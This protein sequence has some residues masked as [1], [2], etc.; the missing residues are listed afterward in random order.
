MTLYTDYRSILI[1]VAP[2]SSNT[3]TGYTKFSFEE[4]SLSIPHSGWTNTKCAEAFEALPNLHNV[5]CSV[6]YSTDLYGGFT[7]LV[8]LAEFP[9]LPYQNNVYAHDGNP[10]LSSFQCDTSEVVSTDSVLCTIT[11]VAVNALP[12]LSPTTRLLTDHLTE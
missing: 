3:F 8:E 2:V 11:D 4:Q 1:T 12:G 7:L 6:E 5:E 9:M 10:P